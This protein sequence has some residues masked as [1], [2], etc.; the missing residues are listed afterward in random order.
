MCNEP[1]N[2]SVHAKANFS[3]ADLKNTLLFGWPFIES[4]TKI[5]NW[6][7]SSLL[8]LAGHCRYPFIFD[9]EILEKEMLLLQLG[10]DITFLDEENNNVL[11]H[12]LKADPDN[13]I[14][15]K[16]RQAETLMMNICHCNR[17]NARFREPRQFL[18]AAITKDADIYAIND[19]GKTPTW[20]AEEYNHEEEWAKALE[21]CGIDIVKV[22]L[23]A[24]AWETILEDL[25]YDFFDYSSE[26]KDRIIQNFN[27]TFWNSGQ[28]RQ[29]SGLSFEEF[30]RL[31]EVERRLSV[32]CEYEKSD[33][34][35]RL[36]LI[37][38]LDHRDD[39]DAGLSEKRN[40]YF[41]DKT[42]VQGQGAASY[43]EKELNTRLKEVN[44]WDIEGAQCYDSFQ[45]GAPSAGGSII[46]FEEYLSLGMPEACPDEYFQPSMSRFEELG[47]DEL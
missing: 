25:Q 22:K 33:E 10:A 41:P 36:R 19:D 34:N 39:K 9:F 12:I 32:N 4:S 42:Q 35:F 23:H 38:L 30:Y 18:K 31:W 24:T 16:E 2:R 43:E 46:G 47:D 11:H 20:M 26:E 7:K 5:Y 29:Q 6:Q 1:R 40:G 27:A 37:K 14:E 13:Y 8:R 3:Q 28:F 17:C 15:G 44:I 21:D 45:L